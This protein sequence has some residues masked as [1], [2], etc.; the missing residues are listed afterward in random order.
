LSPLPG[1]RRKVP[2]KTSQV[3]ASL[4]LRQ[5]SATPDIGPIDSVFGFHMQRASF[6]FAPNARSQRGFPRWELTILSV[7]SANPG[8]SQTAV[9]KALGI[10]QGNLIPQLNGFIKRG[11]LTKAVPA[12]DRRVRCLQLT[13]AGES[14]LNQ[15]L[16]LVRKLEAQRLVGFTE[17]ERK[18]LLDLLRRVHAPPGLSNPLVTRALRRGVNAK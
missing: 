7:V 5:E 2:R 17:P 12:G 16:S 14:R 4:K 9:S 1:R 11:L 6:V 10:D 18:M 3:E 8:I 15:M 13:A